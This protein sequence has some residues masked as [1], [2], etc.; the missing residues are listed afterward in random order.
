MQRM[1]RSSKADGKTISCAVTFLL[2]VVSA[3]AAQ[4]QMF[5]GADAGLSVLSQEGHA[6][7]ICCGERDSWRAPGGRVGGRVGYRS[8]GWF[9]VRA[10]A[11][12]AVHPVNAGDYIE[13]T[14]VSPDLAFMLGVQARGE[15][16]TVEIALGA[17][18]RRYSGSVTSDRYPGANHEINHSARDLRSS[19]GVHRTLAGGHSLGAELSLVKVMIAENIA[20]LSLVYTWAGPG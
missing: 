5:V 13:L 8:A 4:A 14:L 7:P 12:L 2:L 1:T 16:L 6:P 18:W 17:G 11:G 15:K 20:T 19:L 3:S 10:D 9:F